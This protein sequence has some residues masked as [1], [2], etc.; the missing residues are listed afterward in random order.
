MADESYV[1]SEQLRAARSLLRWHQSELSSRSRV[2]L[3]TIKRLELRPGSLYANG[4]TIDALVR[5]FTSAGIEFTGSEGVRLLTVPW[6]RT[7]D[8]DVPPDG[9]LVLANF[10]IDRFQ[11]QPAMFDSNTRKWHLP[12]AGR[13]LE[14]AQV[15]QWVPGPWDYSATAWGSSAP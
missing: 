4:P 1:C 3:P 7:R 10:T 14:E 2:S 11:S 5:A 6:Y 13:V 12:S 9:V 8:G 15:P